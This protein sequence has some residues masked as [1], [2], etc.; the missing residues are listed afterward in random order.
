MAPAPPRPGAAVDIDRYKM[1]LL[2]LERELSQ[3]VERRTAEARRLT[4]EAETDALDE[5]IADVLKDDEFAEVD[6]DTRLLREIR[7][8]LGRIDAGTYGRC[9]VDGGPIEEKRLDAAPWTKYCLKHQEEF[10]AQNTMR[11]PTL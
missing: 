9:A 3:R 6:A 7:D 5:A 11:T 4:D 8:A 10:E 1:K 2:D